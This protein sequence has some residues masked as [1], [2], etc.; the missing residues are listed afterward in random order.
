MRILQ[1]CLPV[2]GVLAEWMEISASESESGSWL[3]SVDLVVAFNRPDP[4]L[5]V[6]CSSNKSSSWSSL[7]FLKASAFCSLCLTVFGL[8]ETFLRISP[9]SLV[10]FL[11]GSFS[12]D[13]ADFFLNGLRTTRLNETTGL[14]TD[15]SG[16]PWSAG[17]GGLLVLETQLALW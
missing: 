12:A 16:R 3:S 6:D 15:L 17:S 5:A 9:M 10:G 4:D 7:K 8:A 14:W 2:T 11:A 13:G 1:Y